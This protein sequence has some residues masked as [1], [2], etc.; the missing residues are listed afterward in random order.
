MELDRRFAEPGG[1][2]GSSALGETHPEFVLLPRSIFGGLRSL[3]PLRLRLQ[4]PIL[5]ASPVDMGLYLRRNTV[6]LPVR[7]LAVQELGVA[8]VRDNERLVLAEV[9]IVPVEI[10]S[11]GGSRGGRGCNAGEAY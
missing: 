4:L 7:E 9:H 2:A 6:E 8:S 1:P 3:L 10:G 11:D 5:E